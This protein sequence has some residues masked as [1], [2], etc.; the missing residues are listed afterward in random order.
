MYVEYDVKKLKDELSIDD[1]NKIVGELGGELRVEENE[2]NIYT[3]ILYHGETANLHKP[4]MYYYF[5]NKM[6]YDYK[7][8]EGF[9]V[10]ELVERVK[11]ESFGNCVRWIGEVVGR[12]WGKRRSGFGGWDWKTEL[13]EY[14]GCEYNDTT[15]DVDI[16]IY[17]DK[18][19]NSFEKKYHT[20]WLN[21]NI[22]IQSMK[23]YNIMWDAWENMIVIPCYDIFGNLIGIRGRNVDKDR[24]FK[25]MPYPNYEFPTNATLYGIE[26]TQKGI[27]K[28]GKVIIFEAEKSVLQCDGYYGD[29]NIA[30]GLYGSNLGTRGRDIIV[31]LDVKEVILGF[32]FDYENANDDDPKF[33][34]FKEKINKTAQLFDGLC[35]VSYMIEYDEH[36][37]KCSPSDRG[38]KKLNEL[39]ENRKEWNGII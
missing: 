30:V 17:D 23:K 29:N 34:K 33:E 22:T 38:K 6:F 37:I 39:I 18:I 5:E 13:G 21:D 19:L 36:P 20:D 26:H 32:D 3:S 9:D 24:D 1:I 15:E 14:M 25:Y 7:L 16:K 8:G 11:E 10:I 12:D 4:K 31:G 35:N 28:H 27:R 2:Y